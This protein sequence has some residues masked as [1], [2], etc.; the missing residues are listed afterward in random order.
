MQSLRADLEVLREELRV[1]LDSSED[2]AR[3][4]ALNEPIGRLSR[5][6]AL[7]Q[8]SMAKANHR[9]AEQRLQR[10]QAALQ[11]LEADEYGACLRCD[12]PV[13]IKRLTAQPEAVL[14]IACQSARETSS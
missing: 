11:R 8:Q 4:V 9:T 7:Q 14:C 5:M 13:G 2:S 3:P 12:E 6:D 10:V 1:F